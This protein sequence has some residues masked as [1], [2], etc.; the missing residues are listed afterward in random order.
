M[1]T[2]NLRGETQEQI[3]NFLKVP[4]FDADASDRQPERDPAV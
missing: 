4:R 1:L 3:L 2:S